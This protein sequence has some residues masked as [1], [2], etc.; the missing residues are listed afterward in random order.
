MPGKRITDKQYEIYMKNKN[1]KYTQEVAAAKAGFCERSGRNLE[2]LGYKPSQRPKKK[3]TRKDPLEGVWQEV[4]VPLLEQ[5]PH[6]NCR[7]LLEYIQ[8]EYPGKYSNSVLRT[9]QKRVKLNIV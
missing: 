3:G 8:D 5:S 4:L 6:L 7:T 1:L 2:K 9:M